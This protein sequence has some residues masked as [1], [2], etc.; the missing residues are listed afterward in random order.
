MLFHRFLV[1][2]EFQFQIYMMLI[3]HI[4]LNNFLGSSLL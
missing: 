3:F 4:K 1:T 2:V